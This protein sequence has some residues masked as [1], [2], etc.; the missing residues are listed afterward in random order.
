LPYSLGNRLNFLA[1]IDLV[2]KAEST[3]FSYVTDTELFV[4]FDLPDSITVNDLS[5]GTLLHKLISTPVD[6]PSSYWWGFAV[7]SISKAGEEDAAPCAAEIYLARVAQM[8]IDAGEAQ[9]EYIEGKSPGQWFVG[10]NGDS[11]DDVEKQAE[12]DKDLFAPATPSATGTPSDDNDISIGS[13]GSATLSIGG[14]SGGT[15][16]AAA[17]AASSPDAWVGTSG[18]GGVGAS[19]QTLAPLETSEKQNDAEFDENIVGQPMEGLG[20]S[21][22]DESKSDESEG[23]GRILD[24]INGYSSALSEMIGDDTDLEFWVMDKIS[25]MGSDI[26]DVK[27]YLESK[28]KEADSSVEKDIHN[29]FK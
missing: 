13:D 9:L 25:R 8:H 22:D 15:S 19:T 11:T 17:P 24:K 20:L 14:G 21:A 18:T 3:D 27:H 28:Q 23:V 2:E 12:S 26:S 5:Q 10:E 4:S 29:E 16:T 6:R 7:S 1:D